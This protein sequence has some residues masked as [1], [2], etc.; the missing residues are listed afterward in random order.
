[1]AAVST[2]ESLTRPALSGA[3][4]AVR[5]LRFWLT[6]YRRTWR[7]SIYSSLLNP[8]LFLGAMGLGLGSLVNSHGDAAIGGVSYLTFLA[9][10]LL[11][12]TAM[13]TAVGES[14]YP[15][16]ASVKWLKTYQ[17]ASASPLRPADFFHGHMLFVALR[18]TGR[19]LED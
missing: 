17:A 3:V 6:N 13:T 19:R 15:V 2:R 11:A 4:F 5:E 9:P 12:A 16:L 1:M 10:G 14:T 18:L 8:L 7:G